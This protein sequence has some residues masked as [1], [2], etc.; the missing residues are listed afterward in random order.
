MKIFLVECSRG[1]LSFLYLNVHTTEYLGIF[2]VLFFKRDFQC[3]SFFFSL[4][5]F[6][7][8]TRWAGFFSW[9]PIRFVG[10]I[11]SFFLIPFIFLWFLFYF[12]SDWIDSKDLFSSSEILPSACC[13]LLWK[14]S[15]VNFISLL[16]FLVPVILIISF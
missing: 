16:I 1:P 5:T 4:W 7:F 13:N 8:P 14:I 6:E 10:F 12:L 9:C 3:F 11:H 2:R 15:T